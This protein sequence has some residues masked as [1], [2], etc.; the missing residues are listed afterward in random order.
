MKIYVKGEIQDIR[1]KHEKK[2]NFLALNVDLTKCDL[3]HTQP[4]VIC[5]FIR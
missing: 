5:F 2:S 3:L 4:L 1:E